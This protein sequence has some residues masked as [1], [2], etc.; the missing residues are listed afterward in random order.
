MSKSEG[1]RL[2]STPSTISD[3][4]Y[5]DGV[6]HSSSS[7]GDA[8]DG[9][10][11]KIAASASAKCHGLVGSELFAEGKVPIGNPID[12]VTGVE[13]AGEVSVVVA[14]FIRQTCRF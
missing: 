6:Y 11:G 9:L 5:D 7:D 3:A 13:V 4:I 10:R 12:L 2:A 1:R 14:D 8:S